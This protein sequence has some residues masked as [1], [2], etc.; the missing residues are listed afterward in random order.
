M[1]LLAV[2][3]LV[4]LRVLQRT[5]YRLYTRWESHKPRS[6]YKVFVSLYSDKDP[7]ATHTLSTLF[8]NAAY[9]NNVTVGL[10]TH[11]DDDRDPIAQYLA[12]C[13]RTEYTSNIRTMRIQS[14]RCVSSARRAVEKYLYTGQDFVLVMDSNTM[15]CN[16]W[17]RML[18]QQ[19]R[20]AQQRAPHPVITSYP[21]HYSVTHR[22]V[23][24][25]PPSTYITLRKFSG[26]IPQL[27]GKL[28]A[29]TPKRPHR[30]LFWS[31]HFSFAS[32]T[33]V[34]DVPHDPLMPTE[35]YELVMACRMYTSGYDFFTAHS[36]AW[37]VWDGQQQD[38]ST[39]RAYVR[40]QLT[41]LHHNANNRR[42]LTDYWKYCGVDLQKQHAQPK[43]YHGVSD[44]ADEDEMLCKFGPGSKKSQPVGKSS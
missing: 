18:L 13:G 37:H 23:D 43:A 17:D 10:V 25:A 21:P 36:V 30:S 16:E 22:P 7:E 6:N 4:A 34:R 19:I 31:S 2:L 20:D 24:E 33:L 26:G 29:Q 14:R 38:T 44:D 32:R 41:D 40:K 39:S 12:T 1:L 28:Y 8:Q 11:H 42:T 35:G 5:A 3:L 15:L 9:P 27:Q